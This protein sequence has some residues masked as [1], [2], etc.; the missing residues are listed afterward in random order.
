M[1]PT[2]VITMGSTGSGKSKLAKEMIDKLQLKNPKFFLI[3]DY[4]ENDK[5]YKQ[6]IKKFSR[7]KNAK[8][9][10]R[11]PDKKTLKYFEKSYFS[12]R[13]NG[14]KKK[15]KNKTIPKKK[16]VDLD[17][18][19]CNLLLS[20]ELNNAILKK[21]NIIFETKGEYYP[22]WL[23]KAIKACN[24]YNIVIAGVKVSLNNLIKRNKNRAIEGMELFLKD[25]NKNPAPRLPDVSEKSLKNQKLLLNKTLKNIILKGCIKGNKKDIDYCS[26]YS[27]DRLLIFD[28][29]KNLKIIYDSNK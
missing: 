4:V 22:K 18:K 27:I 17:E 12:V 15:L 25:T 8:S 19:G 10:L 5:K 6:K 16:C 21:E 11:K 7:N 3:D 28:N 9:K 20:I 13:N 2:L 14:C 24:N 26:K 1:K 29:N 23:I